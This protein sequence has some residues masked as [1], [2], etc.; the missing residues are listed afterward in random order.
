MAISPAT[1]RS[2]IETYIL[3]TLGPA[4]ATDPPWQLSRYAY[5]AFPPLDTD[6][7]LPRSFAVGLVGGSP[8]YDGERQRPGIGAMVTTT[9]GV[10]YVYR[11]RAD[12]H[13]DD[14]ADAL[15]AE[16]PLVQTVVAT[17]ATSQLSAV[18]FEGSQPGQLLG[19][20]GGYMGEVRFSARHFYPLS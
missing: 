12:R 8:A 9:I 17:D 19:D 18:R 10:R 2:R 6:G 20:G 15:A 3:A 1:L 16:P 4:S 5:L 14:Y 13:R 7:V 11:L